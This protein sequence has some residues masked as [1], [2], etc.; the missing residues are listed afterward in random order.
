MNPP[1]DHQLQRENTDLRAALHRVRA[2][3]N[4]L[5]ASPAGNTVHAHNLA[6]A[7]HT[8]LDGAA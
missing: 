4:A 3:A 2:L 7:L 5:E 8:A 6:L 1:A